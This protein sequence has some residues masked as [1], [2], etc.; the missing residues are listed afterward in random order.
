MKIFTAEQQKRADQF[1]VENEPVS[2]IDLMERA[3]HG[4][5]QL[6]FKNYKDKTA[7]KHIFCGNGNNGGDG[8]AIARHLNQAA[9]PVKVYIKDEHGSKDYEK[10]LNR[11]RSSSNIK[12]IKIDE[13][14]T[15]ED[16]ESK[17]FIIDAIFGTGLNR[18]IEG[19]WAN[20]IRQLNTLSAFKMSVD[21]PSGLFAD[22][23]NLSENIIYFADK[24]YTF[25]APKLSFLF[26]ENAQ[27]AKRFEI[28]DIGISPQFR[29]K[30]ACSHYYTLKEDILK[31]Y[32]KR[33][34][35]LHKGN[36]G[37]TLLI[38]G[39]K[40]KI[41]AAI[42]SSKAA[43][44]TGAGLLTTHIPA[45]ALDIMQIS[46]PEAMCSIDK[47]SDFWT[48][49]PDLEKKTIG[50][51]PGIGTDFTTQSTFKSLLEKTQKAMVIDAD[52][53]NILSAN[54][55]WIKLVPPDSILTPHPKEFER[56][57]GTWEND[58]ERLEI[59][60]EFSKKHQVIIV[61]KGANTSITDCNGNVYFNSTGNSGMATAGSGD[62][63]TGM[64]TSLLTQSYSSIDAAVL[65]VYLHGLAGDIGISYTSREALTASDIIQYI[66]QAFKTLSENE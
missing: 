60:K 52:G 28:I 51:G 27:Y 15:L 30:E 63:L 50:I 65:G 48:E 17:D 24:V 47:H 19:T 20:V 14:F 1:T 16:I 32:V 7:V 29:E 37:H 42:L 9:H 62:V 59:Q 25:H 54:Q 36:F 41:G 44:R 5:T 34:K 2:S 53:L 49:I 6:F 43:L 21:I 55:E 18:P 45:S 56:L 22:K 35:F 31:V 33:T 4:F 12:I 64:I 10:N 8:L 58:F 66:G 46:V 61:L 40:G 3:S 39:S 23:H 38:A 11:I 26:P 13:S 57:V